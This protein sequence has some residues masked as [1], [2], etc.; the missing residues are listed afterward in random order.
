MEN[1]LGFRIIRAEEEKH[2]GLE[3]ALWL[4]HVEKRIRIL[5]IHTTLNTLSWPRSWAS[6]MGLSYLG[7]EKSVIKP[8]FPVGKPLQISV[9]LIITKYFRFKDRCFAA[10]MSWLLCQC[11]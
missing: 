9:T 10:T 2:A 7:K 11:N 6:F 3:K 5:P 1:H 4:S 8:P